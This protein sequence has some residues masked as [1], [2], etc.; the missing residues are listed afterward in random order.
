MKHAG[1]IME[2]LE[3]YDLVGMFSGG[4]RLAGC[5]KNT[6]KDHVERRAL[7]ADPIEPAL[8][9]SVIDGYRD[10]VE[11]W[12]TAPT[13]RSARTWCMTGWSRWGSMGR[14]ARPGGRSRTPRT[15]TALG[16]V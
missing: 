3:A 7:G 1:E 16:G 12:W 10:K 15:S 2:I 9:P 4:A 8:Y 11:E 13:V 5:D 14:S 6:V